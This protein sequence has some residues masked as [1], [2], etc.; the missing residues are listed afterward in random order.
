MKRIV[1]VL[2]GLTLLV[3][4]FTVLGTNQYNSAASTAPTST[5]TLTAATVQPD[6]A[7][8]PRPR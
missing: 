2:A 6:E 5:Q 8:Y 3:A 7:Y 4:M 1:K